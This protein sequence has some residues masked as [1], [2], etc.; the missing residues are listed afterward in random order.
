MCIRDRLT[1]ILGSEDFSQM[2]VK[3]DT[4]TRIA[5]HDK[6]LIE[7]LEREKQEIVDA[8]NELAANKADIEASKSLLDAKK[9]QLA[10]QAEEVGN[11]ISSLEDQQA[12]NEKQV[13]QM[14]IRDSSKTPPGSRRSAIPRTWRRPSSR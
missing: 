7:Q 2:L 5:D 14:C 6:Q 3:M 11:S 4:M 8:K 13:A 9:A 12:M 10:S 1:A